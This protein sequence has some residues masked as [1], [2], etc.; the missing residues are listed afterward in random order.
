[1]HLN[2]NSGEGVINYAYMKRLYITVEYA[3]LK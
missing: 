2:D 3:V 1:M